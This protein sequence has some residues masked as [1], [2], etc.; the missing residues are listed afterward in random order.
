MKLIISGGYV[1]ELTFTVRDRKG[2]DLSAAGL[3][4][5]LAPAGTT[6]VKTD[7]GW[8]DASSTAFGI[9]SDGSFCEATLAIS[10]AGGYAV[11]R[12]RVWAKATIGPLVIPVMATDTM[13][14]LA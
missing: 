9:D 7:A 12:Y 6:P 4:F 1:E 13:I 2:A 5:L 10:E 11:G 14:D 8:R 3:K